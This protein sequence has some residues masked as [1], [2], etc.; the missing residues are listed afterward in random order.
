MSGKSY[1]QQIR[2]RV[3]QSQIAFR[4]PA[5]GEQDA[6]PPE[7]AL[8]HGIRPPFPVAVAHVDLEAVVST[9]PS[10]GI[11]SLDVERIIDED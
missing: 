5:G 9:S 4:G 11:P 10:H 3:G 6:L 1:P 8:S 7:F 2:H